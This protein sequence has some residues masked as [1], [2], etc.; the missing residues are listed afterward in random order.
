MDNLFQDFPDVCI[1]QFVRFGEPILVALPVIFILMEFMEFGPEMNVMSV[2]LLDKVFIK[3][4]ILK[5]ALFIGYAV[6]EGPL[7]ALFLKV[8]S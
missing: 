6:V 2:D 4:F 7:K 1:A 8:L 3:I 5:V